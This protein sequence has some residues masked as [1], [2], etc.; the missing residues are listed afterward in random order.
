MHIAK[1]GKQMVFAIIPSMKELPKDCA[2]C[3]FNY[4]DIY[5][6]ALENPYCWE[7]RFDDTRPVWCPLFE[8]K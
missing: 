5:C 3:D 6:V 1:R 7:M 4:D 8:V 2:W